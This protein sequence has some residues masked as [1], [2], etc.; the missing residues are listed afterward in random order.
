MPKNEMAAHRRKALS[1]GIWP[2]KLLST[3][4]HSCTFQCSNVFY[5]ACLL[6]AMWCFLSMSPSATQN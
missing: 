5:S 3:N 1:M 6:P 4:V 2:I